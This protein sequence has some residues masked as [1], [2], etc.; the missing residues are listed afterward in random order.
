[1]AEEA[2]PAEPA[3]GSAPDALP[4]LQGAQLLLLTVA[5]ASA[6]FMEVLDTTIVNVSVPSIAGSLG[7]SPSEATWTI[8][9]YALAAAMVQPLTGWLG[10][11]FGEVRVFVTSMLLFMLTSAACGLAP[12]MGFLVAGRL[13]QGLVS[14]PMVAI[15]QALLLRNFPA[16]KRGV[17]LSIW[18]IVV[19]VAPTLGPVLGG[20]ITDNLSWP[21]L[22][23]INIP[24]GLLAASITWTLLKDRETKIVKVPVDIIGIVLLFVGVGALQYTLDNG[25]ELDWFGS[26]VIIAAS[27][28][29]VVGLAY[30]VAWEL[31]DRHPIIDL[32]LFQIRNFTVA[33]IIT[34]G[35]FFSFMGST[36][37]FPLWLQSAAGYTSTWAG[38]AMAPF[39]ITMLLTMPFVGRNLPRLNKRLTVTV[40][41]LII[42]ASMIWMTRLDEHSS[43]WQ[44]AAPR[45]LMG[46]AMP[47][48]FLPV[49]IILLS[50]VPPEMYASA[51]GLWGFLRS[52]SGSFSTALSVY[53]WNHR[54]DYHHVVLAEHVNV[55]SQGWATTQDAL[56]RIGAPDGAVYALTESAL[57]Q[58]AG[59]LAINDTYMVFAVVMLCLLPV[60]WMARPPFQPAG[61]ASAH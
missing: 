12:S 29:A 5:V 14:G 19:V 45:T 35:A 33:S 2:K 47:C 42:S 53:I 30:L 59:T 51:S 48:F 25:N 18:G 6:T 22:F 9:S 16:S 39:G 36:V 26:P 34:C 7:V 10:R 50:R 37:L 56:G 27:I 43:F 31:T 17:A 40:G 41:F 8:S 15:A 1:M 55:T 46:F 60:L 28:V 52:V 20:W 44:L 13:L 49:N 21:W 11:R 32:H 61:A 54:Q 3:A 38:Y 23:Y 58:Q 4:P 24:T 57:N